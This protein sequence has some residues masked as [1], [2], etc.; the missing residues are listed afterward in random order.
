[1]SSD[2]YGRE[3]L[4]LAESVALAAAEHG[5]IRTYLEWI[6]SLP[7]SKGTD[8]NLDIPHARKTLDAQTHKAADALGKAI[9]AIGPSTCTNRNAS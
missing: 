9:T 1:M 8:D 6:V 7:W 5:V 2:A 3:L 4:A